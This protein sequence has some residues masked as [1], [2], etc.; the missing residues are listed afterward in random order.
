MA[1]LALLLAVAVGQ[2]AVD[3]LPRHM[4]LVQL[5]SIWQTQ[6]CY[7]G[8]RRNANFVLSLHSAP[9]QGASSSVDMTSI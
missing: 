2:E 7:A 9:D 4:S 1:S 3:C 5:S 6:M 8:L